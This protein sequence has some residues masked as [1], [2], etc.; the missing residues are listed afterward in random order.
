MALTTACARPDI[1]MS[2][3][4]ALSM[5]RVYTTPGGGLGA[6]RVH[7]AREI[8]GGGGAEL[9][10]GQFRLVHLMRHR[11]LPT[12]AGWACMASDS[13]YQLR[14]ASQAQDF[15]AARALF[16]EYAAQLN[17]DLC[18][19]GFAAEL[20][21]LAQIYG[22]PSGC[23]LLAGSGERGAAAAAVGCGAVRRFSADSC[24]MKRLYVRPEA[25]GAKLGLLIAQGLIAR[26]RALGYARMLLD[27]L[28]E[29]TPAR[30]LY[31][32]LGF[33]EVA[34]YYNNPLSDV[35]YM[36]LDLRKEP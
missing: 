22:P 19:Q 6:G 23:L 15:D 25:R 32:S 9:A 11:H 29:M 31:R 3:G 1:S 13:T 2:H 12:V 16:E 18:F 4:A 26:A 10:G 36:E 14:E 17:I 33:R 35:V 34:A 21:Q 24:E 5:P 20:G 27:T 28:V 7:G 8:L 30:A